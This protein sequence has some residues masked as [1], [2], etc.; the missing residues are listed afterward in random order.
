MPVTL[1]SLLI[2]TGL[3]PPALIWLRVASRRVPT[4]SKDSVDLAEALVAGILNSLA[5]AAIVVLFLGPRWPDQLLDVRRL[6][7]AQSWTAFIAE[8][9]EQSLTTTALWILATATL[10]YGTARVFYRGKPTLSPHLTVWY[11]VL[12]IERRG[13]QAI[14]AVHLTDG[15]ILEGSVD[16][17]PV[18]SSGD[19]LAIS[20]KQPIHI[21]TRESEGRLPMG[22]LDRVIV[23]GDRISHIGVIYR[24]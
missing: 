21:R 2:F 15:T 7:T 14:I 6:L 18:D 20:L 4:R 3:L 1:T 22:S 24:R 12:G 11:Q 23:H 8:Q 10:A 17:Y 9:I 5:G 13:G 19:D 16:A